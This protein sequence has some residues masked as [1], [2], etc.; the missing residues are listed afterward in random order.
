MF[1]ALAF[2]AISLFSIFNMRGTIAQQRE[3]QTKLEQIISEQGKELQSLRDDLTGM[4]ENGK[5]DELNLTINELLE[6]LET[7]QISIANQQQTIEDLKKTL[8]E[9]QKNDFSG[10]YG[11]II[12]TVKS[13]DTLGKICASLNIDYWENRDLILRLNNISDENIILTGQIFFFPKSIQNR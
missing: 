10:E 13:G 12:Y 2:V 7:Q 9:F 5:L 4:D 6:E 8:E 1:V 3:R 11:Y